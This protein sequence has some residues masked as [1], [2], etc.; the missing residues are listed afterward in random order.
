MYM[1]PDTAYKV[2]KGNTDGSIRVDDIIYVD[3]EDG[4]IVI[5]RWD[6]RFNKEELTDSVT[7]FECEVDSAWEIIRT[8]NTV[9]V[10]RE[11]KK[12]C[13]VL[14]FQGNTYND[15]DNDNKKVKSKES[16]FEMAE[17][18]FFGE[19]ELLTEIAKYLK[20]RKAQKNYPTRVSWEMQL[21]L[22]KKLPKQFRASS[23]RRSTLNGYRQIAFDTNSYTSNTYN[24]GENL[25]FSKSDS[26]KHNISKI[27]F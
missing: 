5:P 14:L 21:E 20:S 10:K 22:L 13:G 17:K 25:T 7:D 4:S 2:T 23:V 26:H 24:T 27:G 15:L 9:L 11:W 16:L 12:W 18:K 3:K 8:A 19:E 6:K 1:K